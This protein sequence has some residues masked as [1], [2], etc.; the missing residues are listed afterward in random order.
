MTKRRGSSPANTRLECT[1][2]HATGK[3]RHCPTLVKEGDPGRVKLGMLTGGER[4]ALL[5]RKEASK[6]HKPKIVGS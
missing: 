2:I 6:R 3:E 5:K 1:E 4:S